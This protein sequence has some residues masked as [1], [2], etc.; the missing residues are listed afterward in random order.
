MAKQKMKTVDMSVK[1]EDLSVKETEAIEETVAAEEGEPVVKSAKRIHIRSRKYHAAKSRVD[2]TKSYPIAQA[3]ELVIKTSYSKFPGSV[4]A[5][6][7]VKDEKVSA[8]VTFPYSTGKVA[9]VA[10]AS[11]EL[12]AKIEAG[13]IEF[14]VLVTH[15]SFMPKL[16]RLAK[17]LGPKG[18]MPNPKNGTVSPDPEKRAKELA[19][20]KTTVKTERKAP[21]MH[22][23]IGK[24]NQEA[25]EIS[26]NV[27]TLVKAV[28]SGRITKLTLS[29]TMS[30][31]VKVD[32]SKFSNA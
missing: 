11:D 2:R 19:G 29:A 25:K 23:I 1:M 15:P 5:D 18:L 10:I 30:P 27:E 13:T 9:R 12:I 14:D 4:V 32:L 26:T 20:G 28:G 21:L 24:T 31:G 16:A 22:V 6:L 17:V 3:V 7:I 8:E